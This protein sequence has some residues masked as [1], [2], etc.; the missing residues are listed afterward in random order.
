MP[1][2]RFTPRQFEAF[3]TV[4]EW[5]SFSLASQRLG[6][7][8]SAVSQLV[9]ELEQIV[10]FRLFD[11]TTRKVTLSAAGLEFLGPAR[12]VLVQLHRAE[13]AAAD[14]RNRAAGLVRVAAPLAI[15]AILLPSAIR[16]FQ[17]ERPKVRIRIRDV[18][19]EGLNDAIAEADSDLAIGPDRITTGDVA[20][21]PM[22]DSPWV[23][24]C[25]ADHALARRRTLRWRDLRDYPIVAAGRDHER[26]VAQMHAALPEDERV[27]PI[28]VVDNITTALGLA[29]KGLAVTLCPAYVA[30]LALPLGLVM[31][32]VVDRE[33]IRQVCLYRPIARTLSPAAEGFAEYLT[34]W[35][36]RWH[37]A[38]AATRRR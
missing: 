10:G 27:T 1:L 13:S 17:L 11:R 30:A 23:L 28:D 25:A 31:R 9:T 24:W 36:P 32:R 26:S 29:A 20:S 2:A 22:F 6:L 7:T 14:V 4:A 21:T 38:L 5:R 12:T 33:V 35:I 18:P 19:V 16:D 15:A 34:G 37:R 3:L 8:A